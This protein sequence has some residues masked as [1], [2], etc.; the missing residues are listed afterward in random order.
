MLG[1]HEMEAA[2]A[3]EHPGGRPDHEYEY[4]PEPPLAEVEKVTDC[5]KSIVLGEAVGVEAEG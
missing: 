4:P 5:P 1:V 3:V 2:F